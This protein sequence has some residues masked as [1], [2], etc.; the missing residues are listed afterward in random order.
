MID[1]QVQVDNI[2]RRMDENLSSPQMRNFLKEI[3][4]ILSSWVAEETYQGAEDEEDHK[5]TTESCL[6]VHVTVTDCRHRYK[7]EVDALPIRHLVGIGEVAERVTGIL[8]LYSNV[9]I[10]CAYPT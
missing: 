5:K 7:S 10:R 6:A 1:K 3:S 4:N 2:K 9:Y 8:N